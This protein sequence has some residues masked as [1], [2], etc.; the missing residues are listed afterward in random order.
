MQVSTSCASYVIIWLLLQVPY[1]FHAIVD[2]QILNVN[3]GTGEK[4]KTFLC[5]I[6]FMTKWMSEYLGDSFGFIV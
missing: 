3:V 2:L 6:F 1:H 4:P 5:N